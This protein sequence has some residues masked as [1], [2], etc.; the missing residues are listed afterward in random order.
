MEKP[1]I[2]FS[3]SSQDEKYLRLLKD[4]IENQTGSAIDIFLSSDGQSIPLGRNWVKKVEEALTKTSLMFVFISPNSLQS[5]WLYFEAGYVYSN[6]V[7]VVPVGILGVNL[8]TIKPPLSLL[9][10]FNL[11]KEDSLGN[12]IG[13][14]NEEYKTKFDYNIDEK[15][16]KNFEDNLFL[17]EN[18]LVSQLHFSVQT[19]IDLL[20][21]IDKK[22][23]NMGMNSQITGDSLRGNGIILKKFAN[24]KIEVTIDGLLLNPLIP[25]I[26]NY[27]DKTTTNYYDE[28]FA[29][30]L[31]P[32]IYISD[33][34]FI[35]Q[36]SLL[37]GSEIT[38]ASQDLFSFREVNFHLSQKIIHF[39]LKEDYFWTVKDI[40]DLCQILF[41]KEIIKKI[42]PS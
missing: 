41:D 17:M 36:T 6:D 33:I 10:G 29:I 3:H 32:N 40:R 35:R 12:I 30:S 11:D 5:N 39:T 38:I 1:I 28:V 15:Y 42:T 9:Q 2:F 7:R 19:S 31:E 34:D 22:L 21:L 14:I 27:I 16:Y 8:N 20:P 4:I 24:N 13:V 18:Q 25:I 26:N 23:I 37:I